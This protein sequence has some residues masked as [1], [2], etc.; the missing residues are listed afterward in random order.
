M[1][2]EEFLLLCRSG[3]VYPYSK[4]IKGLSPM[5]GVP[6]LPPMICCVHRVRTAIGAFSIEVTF[7]AKFRAKLGQIQGRY[8]P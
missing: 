8:K 5:H 1:P 7:F 2:L 3:T 6:W 4:L